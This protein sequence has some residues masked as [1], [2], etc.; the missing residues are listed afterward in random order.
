VLLNHWL[1]ADDPSGLLNEH[2]TARFW[3]ADV[4]Q[5]RREAFRGLFDLARA[6]LSRLRSSL[7]ENLD[8]H[9]AFADLTLAVDLELARLP[10][11]RGQL[12]DVSALQEFR[13]SLKLGSRPTRMQ[14]I[15]LALSESE[16]QLVQ[17]LRRINIDRGKKQG[18][19]AA[20]APPEARF[21][22]QRLGELQQQIAFIRLRAVS[23]L[24][25]RHPAVGTLNLHLAI[26]CHQ[27]QDYEGA[28]EYLDE[29]NACYGDPKAVAAQ[30][31]VHERSEVQLKLAEVAVDM[32]YLDQAEALLKWVVFLKDN[33]AEKPVSGIP[34]IYPAKPERGRRAATQP[35]DSVVRT[36]APRGKGRVERQTDRLGLAKCYGILGKLY[37]YQG[38][39]PDALESYSMDYRLSDSP[40]ERGRYANRAGQV[41]LEEGA[42]DMARNFFKR[43]I[44]RATKLAQNRPTL[45]RGIAHLGRAR[46][47]L[48]RTIPP[49]TPDQVR[50]PQ[51]VRSRRE[52]RAAALESLR[53]ARAELQRLE[54]DQ[55]AGPGDSMVADW[56]D[57]LNAL[58]GLHRAHRL[59]DSASYQP[60]RFEKIRRTL[61]HK[62][63]QFQARYLPTFAGDLLWDLVRLELWA[64]QS[65]NYVPPAPTD[66]LAANTETVTFDRLLDL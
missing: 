60:H 27:H 28:L 7:T 19:S 31:F 54:A 26:A 33:D 56:L 6:H 1:A 34:L 53:D 24:G 61:L 18:Q 47:E 23:D 16:L 15:A 65:K 3:Q 62:A 21:S 12:A 36:G 57:W 46:A 43:N 48:V 50:G 32:G 49:A 5:A 51:Q 30:Q 35:P 38:R 66:L 25:P 13:R 17:I 52:A 8:G 63:W 58:H 14:L 10:E 20:A 4:T 9:P 64:W 59:L 42:Y 2:Q 22:R 40:I 29:A 55:G 45:N 39:L 11:R 37:Y 44:E 41:F